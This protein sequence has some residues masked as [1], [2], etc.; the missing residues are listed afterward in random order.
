[1]GTENPEPPRAST[2]IHEP[3]RLSPALALVAA[4]SIGFFIGALLRCFE[5]ERTPHSGKP[6]RD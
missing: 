6:K 3:S 4:I 2:E 1:M 5:R